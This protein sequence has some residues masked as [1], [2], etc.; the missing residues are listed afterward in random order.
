MS[1]D[2]P[3]SAN[4]RLTAPGGPLSMD[5][6]LLT[7]SSPVSPLNA[8]C[9][10]NNVLKSVTSRFASVIPDSTLA[11]MQA[12]PANTKACPQ[13]APEPTDDQPGN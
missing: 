2:G 1:A 12:P 3:L 4:G 6:P 5:G 9:G 8:V 10:S 13:P 11:S 7:P